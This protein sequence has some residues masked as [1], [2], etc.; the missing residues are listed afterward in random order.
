MKILILNHSVHGIFA[1]ALLLNGLYF[2]ACLLHF[3]S[4]C[5]KFSSI[6]LTL[7]Y[8]IHVYFLFCFRHLQQ[9]DKL[10]ETK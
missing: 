3:M 1:L 2:A 6:Q 8:S 10:T 5:L 4:V 9:S 7:N